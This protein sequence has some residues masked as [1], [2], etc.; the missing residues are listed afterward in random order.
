MVPYFTINAIISSQF[1]SCGA[2]RGF[3]E[4]IQNYKA[5]ALPHLS[6]GATGPCDGYLNSFVVVVAVSNNT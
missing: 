3:H 2:G 6:L 5:L 1:L 4:R